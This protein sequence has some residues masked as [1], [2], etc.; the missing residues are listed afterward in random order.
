MANRP[1]HEA[2]ITALETAARFNTATMET[3]V[4]EVKDLRQ[5]MDQRL[6]K[7][8]ERQTRQET[9][10]AAYENKGKG[11]LLGAG[12]FGAS[13]GAGFFAAAEKLSEIFK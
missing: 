9:K 1:T 13:L 6:D 10:F 8:D 12:I 2:R 3:L 5:H 4:R 11:I 7:I